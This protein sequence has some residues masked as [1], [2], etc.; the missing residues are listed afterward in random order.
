M[1]NYYFDYN[2]HES[3]FTLL[4]WSRFSLLGWEESYGK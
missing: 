3:L 1:F 2:S 4:T